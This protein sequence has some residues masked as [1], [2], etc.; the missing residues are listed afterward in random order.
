MKNAEA[1]NAGGFYEQAYS[2]Y[3]SAYQN[4]GNA[5]ALIGMEQTAK[6]LIQAKEQN[7]NLLFAQGNYVEFLELA[8]DFKKMLSRFREDGASKATDYNVDSKTAMV[9]KHLADEYVAAAQ[10]LISEGDYESAHKLIRMLQ[11][12]NQS[13]PRIDGLWALSEVVESYRLGQEAM[14]LG[15]NHQAFYAF[16][17]VCS[18][19][20]SFKDALKLKNKLKE[21]L[22][23]TIA[24][25][26]SRGFP[27]SKELEVALNNKIQEAI[28]ANDNSLVQVLERVEL[29][30]VLLEQRLNMEAVFDSDYAAEAGKLL[31]ADYIILGQFNNFVASAADAIHET[32]KG[33]LGNSLS[34]AKRVEYDVLSIEWAQQV[35]YAWKL[36]NAE[37][38]EVHRSGTVYSSSRGTESSAS[39]EGDYNN[40]YSGIWNSLS[41]P[42]STDIIF[43][44]L[45]SKQKLDAMFNKEVDSQKFQQNLIDELMDKIAENISI[46]VESFQ[47]PY[48]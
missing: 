3:S 30:D 33:F 27:V 22:S 25:V 36:V 46:E 15:L 26:P 24:Y 19:D 34:L 39:F 48:Y 40:L 44:D 13:D 47:P 35:E 16:E 9:E 10:S 8:P 7:L 17:K 41:A 18:I 45:E 28:V 14:S 23:F 32:K 11:S 4:S 31:G 5:K 21:Q 6:A 43:D 38:G 12:L 42:R 29:E 2:E 37:T 20:A 1:F